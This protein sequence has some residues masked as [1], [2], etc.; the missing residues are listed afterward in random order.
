MFKRFHWRDTERTF[1]A[2]GVLILT[3]TLVIFGVKQ[4]R[5]NP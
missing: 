2:R 1:V 3:V 4:M 5:L